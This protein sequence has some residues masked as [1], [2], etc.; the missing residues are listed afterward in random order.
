M[1]RKSLIAG[2]VA[3]VGLAWIAAQSQSQEKKDKPAGMPEG[4]P[5]MAAMMK[6]WKDAATPGTMHKKLDRF[7]G[8]WDTKMKMWMAGPGAPPVVSEGKSRIK[9]ILDNRFLRE[10][11][12]GEIMMPDETGA[13]SK[14]KFQGLGLLGYDN[15]RHMYTGSWA[16]NQGTHMLT[17]SGALDP[18]GTTLTMYGEMDEAMLDI[19]G[20]TVKYQTKIIDD[21]KHVF[22]IY[23]LHAAEDYKALE[24]EYTRAK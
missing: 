15:F 17:M 21:D 11:F 13:M 3:I 4:M 7:V 16:D 6:K 2:L 23:D 10:E 19:R 12:E 8:E 14:K 20:R 24:I 1:S 18:A 9:W 5:D 22:S